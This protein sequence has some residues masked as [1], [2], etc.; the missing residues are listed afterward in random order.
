MVGSDLHHC[1][2][3]LVE[4]KS[5]CLIIKKTSSRTTESAAWTM[6]RSST[7]TKPSKSDFQSSAI[8]P[9]PYHSWETG[10]N[11][12]TNGIIRQ[13][14]PKRTSMKWLPQER[15]D[16]IETAR[17]PRPRKRHGYTTPQQ[18]FG[19]QGNYTSSLNLSF[20]PLF[21]KAIDDS[22]EAISQISPGPARALGKKSLRILC[23][24]N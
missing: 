20:L 8:L 9:D 13:Y 14:I 5:G 19:S 1:I 7:D 22:D 18:L 16:P 4:R 15:C 11:E 2:L 3:T 24:V 23:R 10:T 21:S 17:N 6:E 12:N